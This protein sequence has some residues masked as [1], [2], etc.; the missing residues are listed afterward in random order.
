MRGI[1]EKLAQIG[2]GRISWPTVLV[3]PCV[4][5]STPAVFSRL[6]RADNPPMPEDL[7]DPMFNEF[8]DW[9]GHQRNDLESPAIAVAPVIGQVLDVLRAE[10]GCRIARMSG[11]GATCFAIFDDNDMAEAAIAAILDS[12]PHWWAKVAIS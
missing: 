2:F 9:L 7:M 3:N 8:P 1:G 4:P 11:S 12:H 5:V 6:A 10:T